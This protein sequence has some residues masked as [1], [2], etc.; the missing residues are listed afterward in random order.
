MS[1]HYVLTQ[2]FEILLHYCGH[3]DHNVVTAS[4][5]TLQQ[6]FKTLPRSL[7]DVL[8]TKHG[9]K[10]SAIYGLENKARSGSKN[11]GRKV[12][13]TISGEFLIYLGSITR[14]YAFRLI[15]RFSVC[16]KTFFFFCFLVW[17]HFNQLII[18]N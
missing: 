17:P 8:V 16:T 18:K 12:M 9:M 4:L 1:S 3:S 5:E 15:L 13:C 14:D 7:M 6:L 11:K 2:V 10:E